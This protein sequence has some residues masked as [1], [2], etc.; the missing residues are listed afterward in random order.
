MPDEYFFQTLYCA[1]YENYNAVIVRPFR[2]RYTV[3]SSQKEAICGGRWENMLCVFGI[4]DLQRLTKQHHFIAH[5]FDQ[6]REPAVYDC[7]ERWLL[8]KLFKLHF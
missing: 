8:N 1:F 4:D 3:W 5:R 6:N 2:T 7:L